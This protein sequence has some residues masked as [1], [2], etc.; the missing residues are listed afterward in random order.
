MSFDGFSE[1]GTKMAEEKKDGFF[2]I[3]DSRGRIWSS[4][5]WTSIL[6]SA[7]RFSSEENAWESFLQ[8]FPSNIFTKEDC[9]NKGFAVKYCDLAKIR[10]EFSQ[11]A[12]LL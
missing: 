4:P 11:Y 5:T 1:I 3:T 7:S 8:A 2:Y 6:K 12:G 10:K 9:T